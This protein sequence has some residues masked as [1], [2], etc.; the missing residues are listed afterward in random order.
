MNVTVMPINDPPDQPKILAPADGI[1]ID[2]GELLDFMGS[3]TD[4]DLLYGDVLKFIWSDG[5]DQELGIGENLTGVKLSSG[6]HMIKLEVIDQAGEA[7]ST[8]ISITVNKLTDG[9]EDGDKGI[10]SFTMMLIALVI[11][12]IVLAVLAFVVLRKKPVDE[13]QIERV[14]EPHGEAQDAQEQKQKTIETTEPVPEETAVE[15]AVETSDIDDVMIQSDGSV[16]A[17]PP[18]AE[19]VEEED[20]PIPI[21]SEESVIDDEAEAE[22]NVDEEIGAETGSVIPEDEVE[23]PKSDI[24]SEIEQ[25]DDDAS[26][27]DTPLAAK[28][29][30]E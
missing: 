8:S 19:V 4:P 26:V 20:Q 18:A 3:C 30:N 28:E 24:K 15:D 10:D 5:K 22:L 21:Q 16:L 13:V 27:D 14:R 29:Q 17:P 6:K 11:I 23:P 2:E 7:S 9:D 1:T 25:Q 12:V